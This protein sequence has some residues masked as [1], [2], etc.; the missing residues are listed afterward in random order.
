MNRKESIE[1]FVT[2]VRSRLNRHRALNSALWS[3]GIGAA[4]LLLIASIYILRGYAVPVIWYPL[5]ACATVAGALVTISVR[6]L[7]RSD[8]T[9][10]AD[11]FFE[12]KDSITSTRE[13]QKG[14]KSGGLYE[15]Q[16]DQTKDAVAELKA[17]SIRYRWPKGLA[18]LC[19]ALVGVAVLTAFKEP[20]P[21]VRKKLAV[22]QQTLALTGQF[23]EKMREEIE[24]LDKGI[25]DPEERKLLEA[26]KLRKWVDELK[27]TKN[28]KEAMRRMA[29]LEKKITQ[30]ANRLAQRKT[31]QLLARVAKEL[32]KDR[33]HKELA[34]KLKQQNYKDAKKDIDAL[35]PKGKNLSEQ[36]KQLAKLKSAANRMAAASRSAKTGAKGNNANKSGNGKSKS[37][38]NLMNSL[39]DD[40]EEYEDELEELE[41]AELEGELSDE[42]FGECEAC[43]AKIGDKLA[44][45]NKN[46]GK[47]SAAK[48][49]Q[50]KLLAMCKKAGQCQGCLAGQ[51]ESPF[52]KPGGHKP[53]DGTIE[54]R[55]DAKDELA[56]NGQTTQLKGMKGKGPSLSKLESA[57]DGTGVS[58]RNAETKKRTFQRQFESF[59]QRE[60]VPEDVKDGV[61]NYFTTI[62]EGADAVIEPE[63]EP[64]PAKE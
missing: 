11:G 26:D 63:P 21:E 7:S 15:L 35:K 14:D 59:V 45:M 22:E 62:H 17:D 50:K 57:E 61:R 54:S 33:A 64:E 32:D 38:E 47:L 2:R 19:G 48:K 55:R 60:D 43:K 28:Q 16:R 31:E 24:E 23:S 39:A 42:D 46:L 34:R 9:H 30:M 12:L 27:Q 13:F 5:A 51:C 8:A 56:D 44:Q 25:D 36:K 37:M 58:H 29:D 41:L 20:S 40:V 6:R 4:V 49:L 52:A 1:T 10:F 18:T 3:L 53:G